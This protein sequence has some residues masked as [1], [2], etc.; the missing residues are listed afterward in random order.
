MNS[1]SS[2]PFIPQP[3]FLLIS[4]QEGRQEAIGVLL[5]ERPRT[6]RQQG[7]D[8]IDKKDSLVLK[9]PQITQSRTSLFNLQDLD[10]MGR[11]LPCNTVM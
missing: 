8:A 6:E 7:W 9:E 5:L 11:K 3:H 4:A 2:E 10:L 1:A